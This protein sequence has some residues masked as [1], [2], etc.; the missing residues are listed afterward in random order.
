[1]FV[2]QPGEVPAEHGAEVPTSLIN[3]TRFDI[4][5]SHG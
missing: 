5:S 2:K 1:M 3:D 4:A